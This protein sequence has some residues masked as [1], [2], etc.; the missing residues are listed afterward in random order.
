MQ[1][2]NSSDTLTHEQLFELSIILREME[3]PK[4]HQSEVL[5][6]DLLTLLTCG[7]KSNYSHQQARSLLLKLREENV[8]A[9]YTQA[10]FNVP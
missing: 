4:G 1:D 7:K 8:K 5:Q 10:V 6:L 9:L 2:Q 3:A